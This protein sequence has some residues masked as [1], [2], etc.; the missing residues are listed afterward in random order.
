MKKD[1]KKL[2]AGLGVASLISAGGVAL[3]GAHAAGSGWSAKPS[4]GSAEVSKSAAASGW[5]GHKDSA[6]SA[7]QK[8]AEKTDELLKEGEKAKQHTEEH[9]QKKPAKSGWSGW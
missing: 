7:G 3:P 5:S 6:V 2:L 1:V 4:A 9:Q 8:E